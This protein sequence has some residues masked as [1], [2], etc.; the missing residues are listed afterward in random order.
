M[1]RNAQPDF[2][3]YCTLK[4]GSGMGFGGGVPSGDLPPRST[5]LVRRAGSGRLET[6]PIFGLKMVC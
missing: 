4:V 2:P 5:G 3:E 6:S 1:L